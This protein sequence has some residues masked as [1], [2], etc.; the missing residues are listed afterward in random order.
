MILENE[1]DTIPELVLDYKETDAARDARLQ[2]NDRE[3]LMYKRL[4]KESKKLSR[5]VVSDSRRYNLLHNQASIE[6]FEGTGSAWDDP[7]PRDQPTEFF[8][9]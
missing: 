1:P 4:N 7:T 3:L 2:A 8:N 9:R 5:K 6:F